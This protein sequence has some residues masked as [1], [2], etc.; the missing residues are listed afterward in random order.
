[1]TLQCIGRGPDPDLRGR[2]AALLPLVVCTLGLLVVGCSDAL[3]EPENDRKPAR[4][5]VSTASGIVSEGDAVDF[6]VKVID[7]RGDVI[8]DPPGWARSSLDL[9]GF[10]TDVVRLEDGRLVAVGP[11]QSSVDVGAAGLQGLATVRVNP[12]EVTT[13]VKSVTYTQSTQRPDNSI[14][15][16]AGRAAA[17]RIALQA[18]QT[19]FFRPL[20]A[21]TV[22]APGGGTATIPATSTASGIPTSAN[23][24]SDATY[25]AILPGE[26]V[27]PG[28]RLSIDVNADGSVP[29]T[30]GSDTRIP[31]VGA[32]VP[33]VRVLSS[34]GADFYPV[35]YAG[36]GAT[37]RLPTDTPEAFM[38]RLVDMF[39]IGEYDGRLMQPFTT[40]IRPAS[41]SDWA[42][43]LNELDMATRV[44]GETRYA[45][46][47]IDREISGGA[48][49]IAYIGGRTGLGVDRA[50]GALETYA[51]EV[52]H[53]L[54]QYHAPC[55]NPSGVDPGFPYRT[56][57]I[58]EVGYNVRTGRVHDT[59]S[60][61][62]LM[63]YCDPTWISDY[64]YASV[65]GYRLF[66]DDALSPTSS[67]PF[68]NVPLE[69][70]QPEPVRGPKQEVL[71]VW[72]QM[73]K[74]GLVL[75]P[76]F[77]LQA[78]SVLPAQDGPYRL[79]GRDEA[80]A[81]LFS[82]SF[83]GTPVAHGPDGGRSFVFAIPADRAQI[84]RLH[85]LEF[86]GPT[87][88]AKR[89]ALSDPKL[90][91]PQPKLSPVPSSAIDGVAFEWSRERHAAVLI[92]DAQTG[93]VLALSRDGRTS[94]PE[95]VREVDA[96]FSNGV[97]ST[98]SRLTLR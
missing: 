67:G 68:A 78:P 36:N 37:G 55:G 72:G 82:L 52:G 24:S 32:L 12:T 50:P 97:R 34:F 64:T 88:A 53:S 90:V 5:E 20:I 11:G 31:S 28:M 44:L 47:L 1:M 33:D 14:P 39:P 6:D 86:T 77:T 40:S 38:Q 60:R 7:R 29:I 95:G 3:L 48:A 41:T 74:D 83:A 9:S 46:G 27:R 62:D 69:R 59:F 45:Y 56:G 54:Y 22:T 13:S 49:G 71:L 80:G 91:A 61:K 58:G 10:D 35:R 18:D 84:D 42:R 16:V 94:L 96:S 87:G 89:K 17:V 92:R 79:R 85:E 19:N 70:V 73:S 23:R 8:P 21:V 98:T 15:L 75:E 43:I 76:A 93:Q 65:F 51:H 26:Q 66:L 30:D 63:T 2:L 25:V 81:D 4:L 57:S